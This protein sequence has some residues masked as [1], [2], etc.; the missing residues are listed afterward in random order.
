CIELYRVVK[1]SILFCVIP[2]Q[3]I[4]PSISVLYILETDQEIT[5]KTCP[6]P[7][8]CRYVCVSVCVCVCVGV[9]VRARARACAHM[10]AGLGVSARGVRWCVCALVGLCVYVCVCVCVCVW[11][12]GCG[13][14][15]VRNGGERTVEPSEEHYP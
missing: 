7:E 5:T 3:S 2:G 9:G 12:C 1:L 13:C 8:D 6:V 15:S 10:S 11:G 4:S 14:V